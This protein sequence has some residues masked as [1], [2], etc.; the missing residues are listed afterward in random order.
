M[1]VFDST[2]ELLLGGTKLVN[3]NDILK[4]YKYLNGLPQG[5]FNVIRSDGLSVNAGL[6]DLNK[7]V[8]IKYVE[9]G[10]GEGG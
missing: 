4:K 3:G 1:S 8:S 6:D 2:G 9:V 7:V 5:S 10:T